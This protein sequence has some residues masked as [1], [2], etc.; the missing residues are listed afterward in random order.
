MLCSITENEVMT[1]CMLYI[2][3]TGGKVLMG[4]VT[5]HPFAQSVGSNAI[6]TPCEEDVCKS[7]KTKRDKM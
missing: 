5:Y 7:H 3:I 1:W 4:E 2:N 6:Q